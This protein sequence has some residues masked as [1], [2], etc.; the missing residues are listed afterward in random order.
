VLLPPIASLCVNEKSL[1]AAS[2]IAKQENLH[3]E[4]PNDLVPRLDSPEDCVPFA[5]WDPDEPEKNTTEFSSLIV[6]LRVT[7][8]AGDVLYL[9][10]LWY[11]KVTLSCGMDPFCCS[12]NYW[13]I[14]PLISTL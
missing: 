14:C 5:T 1:P 6:P 4:I 10:A 3:S 11:H 2:Y 9:P 13:Y 7:L 8:E 12:V